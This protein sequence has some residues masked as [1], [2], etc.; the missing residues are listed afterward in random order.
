MF[1][2]SVPNAIAGYVAAR[3]H[4][5]GPVVCV[6]GITAGLQVAALLIDDGDA[7]EALVVRVDLAVTNGDRDHGAAI[8]L[9]RPSGNES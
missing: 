2:Q 8:L 3:W 9:T 5:T 6:S 7:T 4:L 1:F